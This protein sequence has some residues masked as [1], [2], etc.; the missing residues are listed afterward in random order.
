MAQP[1]LCKLCG[2]E[3]WL[4][5]PHVTKLTTVTKHPA[6]DYLQSFVTRAPGR[7]R[8]HADNAARQRAY[9]ERRRL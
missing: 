9:R 3:H 5:E 6:Q 7:P 4:R 8:T 2:H 1:P